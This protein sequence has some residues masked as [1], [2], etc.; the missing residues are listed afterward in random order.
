VIAGKSG[1]AASWAK[2]RAP[3]VGE[4]PEEYATRLM[5]EKYGKGNWKRGGPGDEFSRIQKYG[6]R[7]W[8]D[9]D[10]NSVVVPD[11]QA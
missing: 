9:P 1:T 7:H 3:Y 6:A 11:D 2:G 8:R 4:T 10:A 5:D